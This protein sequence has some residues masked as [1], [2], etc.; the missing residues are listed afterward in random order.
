MRLDLHVHTRERSACGK[1]TEEA[2]IKAAIAVGLDG[3]VF[4]D[5]DRLAP[6][7]RLCEL[8][9]QYA[10]F[11]IFGGIEIS[12]EEGEHVLV[13]GLQAPELQ[14][15]RWT[16]PELYGFIRRRE[17]FLALNHP[18][19]YRTSLRI[20]I[21]RHPPDAIELYS[22]NTPLAAEDQ[23]RQLASHLGLRVLANSDA[24]QTDRLGDYYNQLAT[25]P[26]NDRELVEALRQGRYSCHAPKRTATPGWAGAA[27][28][29]IRQRL[30]LQPSPPS[31]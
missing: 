13:L 1:A 20:D 3:L 30:K 18:F 26:A 10:P 2:M 14:N 22:H 28:T 5:H 25:Q 19:R 12:L 31:F 29:H 4:T 23:I 9:A 16:Y 17:G 8:N 7:T 11:H 27:L 15:Q 6:P 21:T 24:H